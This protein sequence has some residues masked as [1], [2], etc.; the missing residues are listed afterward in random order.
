MPTGTVRLHRVLRADPERVY[1]AFLDA[2]A[3]AKWL[4]PYGFTC[5]V[6][7]LEAKVGGTLIQA[8]AIERMA[9]AHTDGWVA[10]PSSEAKAGDIALYRFKSGPGE[11]EHGELVVG[12]LEDGKFNDVGGNTSNDADGSQTNGGGVFAKLR[13]PSLLTCIARPLY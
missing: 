8:A 13:D 10:V 3:M 4:P 9:K 11:P 12:P 2:D 1:R 7:H 6:H 5:K